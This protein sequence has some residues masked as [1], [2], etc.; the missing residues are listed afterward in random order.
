MNAKDN[1][2]SPLCGTDRTVVAPMVF[3]VLVVMVVLGFDRLS[4]DRSLLLERPPAWGIGSQLRTSGIAAASALAVASV[5]RLGR[6]VPGD[7]PAT[8][9]AGT[10][11]AAVLGAIVSIA[12]AG[13]VI[14]D[15]GRLTSLAEEDGPV[16]W[17]SAVFAF[18]A[19]AL[20]ARAAVAGLRGTAPGSR[21]WPAWTLLAVAGLALLVGL[22]EVSWFQ[23]VLD[24]ESPAAVQG[25]NQAEFNLHNGATALSENLYYV[26]GFVLLVAIPGLLADVAF[27]GRWSMLAEVVPGSMV[28]YGTVSAAAFV[29]EMWDIVPIQMTFFASLA[30]L[31]TDRRTVG[32][33]RLGR[34]VAAVMVGVAAVFLL[35]GSRMT[36]SWDDTEVRELLLAFGLLL[37]GVDLAARK[38]DPQQ[39]LPEPEHRSLD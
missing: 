34:P 21:R 4:A 9:T 15:P 8:A 16:E 6:K 23:R 10:V 32:R 28:L 25:R 17:L 11:A 26:G 12:G 3:A 1:T 31:V 7:H 14:L 29:Y 39:V 27:P 38:L 35:G 13:L 19:A 33:H 18:A 20:I 37:Y 36:R 24:I 22:E 5:R 2:R 30:V